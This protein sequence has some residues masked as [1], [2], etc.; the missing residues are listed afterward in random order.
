MLCFIS[1]LL[2]PG[3]AKDAVKT[4]P[5]PSV[6]TTVYTAVNYNDLLL[7]SMFVDTFFI[8]ISD[9]EST[10]SQVTQFYKRR[11]YQ[12]AWFDKEGPSIAMTIFYDQLKSYSFDFNDQSLDNPKIDSLVKSLRANEVAFMSN[13][14][15]VLNLEL[16]LTSTYFKY[17]RKVYGG[18]D[19]N[20]VDLEWFIP[21][22]KK[23]YQILLDSL[24]SR[25]SDSGVQEP[26][27]LYYTRLKAELRKYR[28]LEIKSSFFPVITDKKVL[29]VGDTDICIINVKK[30]LIMV[31]DLLDKDTSAIFT[32]TLKKALV[33]FQGRMGLSKSGKLYES[34][35]KELN[36]SISD[37][38]KQMVIN[39]ERLRWV[40]VDLEPD[41]L[42]E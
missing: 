23:N 35:R 20:P 4:N 15:N 42:M 1:I 41:Y 22:K 32:D 13:P 36:V 12:F 29:M 38:I 21:R 25:K 14:S 11:H 31:G 33:T 8:K 40:P 26:E 17:A 6:D 19:A 3:C 10:K 2:F 24:I 7:D 16:L 9:S 37:R 28:D 30:N 18:Q 39:L 27:N 5:V 34:T